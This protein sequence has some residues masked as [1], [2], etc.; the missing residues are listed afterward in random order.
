MVNVWIWHSFTQSLW[1]LP[2]TPFLIPVKNIYNLYLS[3]RAVDW[4]LSYNV[5]NFPIVSI[6]QGLLVPNCYLVVFL[7]G[8]ASSI[9]HPCQWVSQSEIVSAIASTELAS[10]LALTGALYVIVCHMWPAGHFL[11]FHSVHYFF[12]FLCSLIFYDFLWCFMR[13]YDVLWCFMVF[14]DVLWCSLMF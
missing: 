6:C 12:Q 10:L 3:M 2:L 1:T 7:D 8:I 4:V 14:Y 13:F 5:W 9:T 11:N